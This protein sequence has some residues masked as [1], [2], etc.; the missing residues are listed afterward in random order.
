ML[1]IPGQGQRLHGQ[2]GVGVITAMKLLEGYRLWQNTLEH[3]QR[4]RSIWSKSI[5]RYLLS[6]DQVHYNW[7]DDIADCNWN[8]TNGI[9]NIVATLEFGW[10][11]VDD[12]KP[13]GDGP[14]T[15][16]DR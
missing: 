7:I 9:S 13:K 15:C 10:W 11:L 12:I 16:Y 5:I 1:N 6:L 4:V 8:S 14:D 3:G 2:N